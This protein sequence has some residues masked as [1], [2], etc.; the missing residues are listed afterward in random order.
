MSTAPQWRLF[1]LTF[2][3]LPA[4]SSD[5]GPV[6]GPFSP[7]LFLKSS[8]F[9]HC[10]QTHANYMRYKE[11]YFNKATAQFWHL[12]VGSVQWRALEE[13]PPPEASVASQS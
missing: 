8:L 9:I 3:L 12:S 6:F 11:M 13:V 1:R 10:M 4:I 5:S 7:H 2:V